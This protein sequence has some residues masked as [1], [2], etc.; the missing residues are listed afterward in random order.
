MKCARESMG[1]AST[2]AGHT[3]LIVATQCVSEEN[4]DMLASS[5][6][7]MANMCDLCEGVRVVRV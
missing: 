5:S 7:V 6:T 2:S 1:V 3:P 4:R